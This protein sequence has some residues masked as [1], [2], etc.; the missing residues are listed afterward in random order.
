[1]KF[2]PG[3]PEPMSIGYVWVRFRDHGHFEAPAFECAFI[4]EEPESE[5]G[6][7][8]VQCWP[9]QPHTYQESRLAW[10]VRV[11]EGADDEDWRARIRPPLQDA[12]HQMG[13]TLPV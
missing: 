4:N 13:I 2:L 12:L 6:F 7:V 3:D 9:Y 8:D 11:P 10:K 5:Q 1:M